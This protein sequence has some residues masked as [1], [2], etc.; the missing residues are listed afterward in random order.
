MSGNL[1]VI[2]MAGGAE[3]T[4]WPLESVIKS[5]H[6]L[7]HV[8]TKCPRPKEWPISWTSDLSIRSKGSQSSQS[9]LCKIIPESRRE[10]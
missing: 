4:I 7:L 1:K 2:Y 3:Y 6:T 5:K 10:C 8:Y 9:Y